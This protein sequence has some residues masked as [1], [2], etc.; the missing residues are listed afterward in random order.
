MAAGWLSL[1]GIRPELPQ[2]APTSLSDVARGGILLLVV[3]CIIGPLLN[4][5]KAVFNLL[6]QMPARFWPLVAGFSLL[7][8]RYARGRTLLT[9]F[10]KAQEAV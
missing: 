6:G 4:S 1:V 8:W 10:A 2:S 7:S 5:M 3:L 9:T